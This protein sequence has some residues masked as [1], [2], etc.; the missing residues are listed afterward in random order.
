M[1]EVSETPPLDPVTLHKPSQ[2]KIRYI[3]KEWIMAEYKPKLTEIQELDL[4]S[5]TF[6]KLTGSS[7]LG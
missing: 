2:N 3:D 4:A 7:Y 1:K 5:C 6:T